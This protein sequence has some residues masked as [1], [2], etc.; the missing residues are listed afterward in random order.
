MGQLANTQSLCSLAA[1][2]ASALFAACCAAAKAAAS[3]G[4]MLKPI[5]NNNAVRHLLDNF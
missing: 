4:L 1:P 5:A 2:N 3:S